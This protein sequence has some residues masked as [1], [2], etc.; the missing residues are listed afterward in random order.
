MEKKC[1][2]HP[3]QDAI[4]FCHSCGDSYCRE[5][6]I[7]GP[8]YY[9]CKKEICKNKMQNDILSYSKVEH[10]KD[11][12]NKYKL[13]YEYKKSKFPFITISLIIA[14]IMS[15]L[16]GDFNK[17]IPELLGSFFV[18]FLGLWGIPFVITILLGFI[19]TKELRAKLFYYVY[20]VIWVIIV[21]F[22]LIGSF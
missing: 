11:E 22:S 9:Y 15:S 14:L 5:C 20:F 1:K 19:V 2:N 17:A 7:E 21:S 10:V 16:L 12:K 4:S 3:E 18:H 6:L 8:E 13:L